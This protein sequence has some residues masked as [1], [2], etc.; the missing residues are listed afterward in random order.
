MPCSPFAMTSPFRQPLSKHFG[1]QPHDYPEAG[2]RVVQL[3]KH[4]TPDQEVLR[5]N[6]RWVYVIMLSRP[7]CKDQAWFPGDCPGSNPLSPPTLNPP[8][9]SHLSHPAE[10]MLLTLVYPRTRKPTHPYQTKQTFVSSKRHPN[11]SSVDWGVCCKSGNH[12]SSNP[13]VCYSAISP[14]PS[15]PALCCPPCR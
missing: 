7:W 12:A 14:R 10:P 11:C 3:S 13:V 8:L 9:C 1:V 4:M 2:G 5:S 6:P 15:A